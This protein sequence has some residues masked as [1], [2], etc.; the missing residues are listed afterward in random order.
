MCVFFL[1]EQKRGS[2]QLE[3]PWF[4]YYGDGIVYERRQEVN[5]R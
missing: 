5:K 2:L 4:S 1:L 3:V